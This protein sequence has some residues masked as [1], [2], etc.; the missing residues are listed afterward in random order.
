MCD[1]CFQTGDLNE[2]GDSS[3]PPKRSCLADG[4]AK[5]VTFNP[6]VQE[7]ALHRAPSPVTLKEVANIVV[8]FLDPFYT[9]GKFA[10]K[11]RYFSRRCHVTWN[12]G[13]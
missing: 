10:T 11:V 13:G 4:S 7:R 3:P 8:R 1:A 5:R 2:K 6:N 9:Q 12:L